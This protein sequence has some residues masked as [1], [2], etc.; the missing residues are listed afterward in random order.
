MAKAVDKKQLP[1]QCL[2][3][4]FQN[5]GKLLKWRV[6]FANKNIA[7]EFIELLRGAHHLSVCEV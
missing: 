5:W 7:F 4:R 6:I 1:I 2:N 3:A